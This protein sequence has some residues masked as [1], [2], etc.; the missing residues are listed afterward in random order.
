MIGKRQASVGIEES[1]RRSGCRC[2]LE[3][4]RKGQMRIIPRPHDFRR[5]IRIVLLCGRMDVIGHTHRRCAVHNVGT[6]PPDFGSRANGRRFRFAFNRTLRRLLLLLLRR[7]LSRPMIENIQNGK[8]SDSAAGS[9]ILGAISAIVSIRPDVLT[10]EY[11]SLFGLHF[12]LL[13]V[14]QH[15]TVS[16]PSRRR[17]TH[18]DLVV[19]AVLIRATIRRPHFFHVHRTNK[20][21]QNTFRQ[22]GSIGVSSHLS[23]SW[24]NSKR[25][26]TTTPTTRV[27]NNKKETI[28]VKKKTKF[29]NFG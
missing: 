15:S 24:N 28:K 7:R 14:G 23:I 25:T 5:R 11:Q 1:G 19:T 2:G 12:H 22:S 10:S 20:Q 6:L 17:A 27:H 29:R 4:S 21:K 18:T 16:G 13:V 8:G 9:A 3:V 26:K